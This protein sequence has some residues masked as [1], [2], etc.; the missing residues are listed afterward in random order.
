[1]KKITLLLLIGFLILSCSESDKNNNSATPINYNQ[2]KAYNKSIAFYSYNSD[3][4]K[5]G[6]YRIYLD[7]VNSIFSQYTSHRDIG[8]SETLEQFKI[9][10]SLYYQNY[11]NTNIDYMCYEIENSELTIVLSHEIITDKFIFK[12]YNTNTLSTLPDDSKSI[13]YFKKIN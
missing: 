10:K 8:Q 5:N 13:E 6:I 9:K 3:P 4:S 12:R 11:K 7:S 1:M 2:L